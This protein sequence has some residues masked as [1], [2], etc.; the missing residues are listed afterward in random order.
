MTRRAVP[1]LLARRHRADGPPASV[2]SSPLTA[3]ACGPWSS[4][5]TMSATRPSSGLNIPTAMPLVYEL[6]KDLKP[7]K[8]Y[9]L[10]DPEKVAKPPWPPSPPRA[11]RSRP[12]RRRSCLH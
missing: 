5:W 7:I 1:A 10:G 6:D 12:P 8:N 4:T 3:T 2:W 9:Y 11:R